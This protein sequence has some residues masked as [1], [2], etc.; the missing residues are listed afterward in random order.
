MGERKRLTRTE[1]IQNLVNEGVVNPTEIAQITGA[2]FDEIYKATANM[3]GVSEEFKLQKKETASDKVVRMRLEEN[4]SATEV[5]Q[6]TGLSF[7][8]QETIL[9]KYELGKKETVDLP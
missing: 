5:A 7:R 9:R 1:R 6:S 2:H 3:D 8:S 4:L